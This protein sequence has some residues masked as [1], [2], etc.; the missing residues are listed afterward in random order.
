MVLDNFKQILQLSLNPPT[1]FFPFP[2]VQFFILSLINQA[3]FE[4]VIKLIV[5]SFSFSAGVNLWNH[6]NDTKEDS[7]S[8]RENIFVKSRDLRL[9]GI[10][11]GIF[12]YSFSLILT[13]LWAEDS[14]AISFFLIVAVLTWL[15]SDKM[16]FGRFLRRLKEHYSTEFATYSISWPFFVI[17]LWGL[18][19][20]IVIDTY[21]VSLIFLF[22][23]LWNVFLKDLKDIRG[24][25]LAGL[26]TLA[27][28]FKPEILYTLSAIF[29]VLYYSSIAAFSLFG[30][31]PVYYIFVSFFVVVQIYTIIKL[32]RND[33]NFGLVVNQLRI[34]P[35]LNIS[36][37]VIMVFLGFLKF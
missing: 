24:D 2:L 34:I 26:Q 19:S 11:L 16:I 4:I 29:L 28:R 32:V 5:I 12:L 33:W 30:L 3:S 9:L 27:V 22:F 13:F 25:S 20:K 7:F 6:V 35:L 36:S 8:G 18:V 21:L 31:F 14:K 37:L 15:Y 1:I 17:A 10:F 23:G